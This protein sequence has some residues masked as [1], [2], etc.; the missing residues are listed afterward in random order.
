[1]R[2]Q[3]VRITS[4]GEDVTHGDLTTV[5]NEDPDH[6]TTIHYEIMCDLGHW[7]KRAEIPLPSQPADVIPFDAG[8][9]G[10]ER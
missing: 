5:P 4:R 10:D 7:H 9:R 8:V 3:R 2:P 1:M 6:P